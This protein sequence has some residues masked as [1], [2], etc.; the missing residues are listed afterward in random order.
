MYDTVVSEDLSLTVYC[1]DKYIT[2]EMCDEVVNHCLAPL[3]LIFDWFVTIKMIKKLFT[4]LYADENV[5]YFN[6]GSGDAIFSCSVMG[7]LNIIFNNINLD[8]DFDGD[9][10]VS[11]YIDVC[12]VES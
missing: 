3:K 6:E 4:D 8:I 1:P 10:F 7:I 2:R 12:S 9:W 11:L 5:L